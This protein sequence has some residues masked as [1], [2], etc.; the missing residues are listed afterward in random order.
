MGYWKRI[1]LI[2]NVTDAHI[3]AVRAVDN[4]LG[5]FTSDVLIGVPESD[6]DTVDGYSATELEAYVE[7]HCDISAIEDGLAQTAYPSE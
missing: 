5:T 1:K 2:D 7:A 3:R 6:I 4:D